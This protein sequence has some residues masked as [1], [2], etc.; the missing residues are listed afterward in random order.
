MK[1]LKH[2]HTVLPHVLQK[3]YRNEK[4][5]NKPLPQDIPLVFPDK[6]N[7]D[8]VNGYQNLTIPENRRIRSVDIR[9]PGG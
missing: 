1:F 8:I 3:A 4:L 6:T 2:A 5:Q 7:R 9:L